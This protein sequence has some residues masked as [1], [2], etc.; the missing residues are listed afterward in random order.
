M[1]CV[2]IW[3]EYLQGRR[4]RNTGGWRM[5]AHFLLIGEVPPV[6]AARLQILEK[7]SSLCVEL[8]CC[9]CFSNTTT[10]VCKCPLEKHSCGLDICCH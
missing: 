5:T 6:I 3:D 2:L 10:D 9:T 8:Y 1:A 7:E 4:Q